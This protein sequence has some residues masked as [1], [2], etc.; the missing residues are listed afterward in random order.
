MRRWDDG[1]ISSEENGCNPTP[2]FFDSRLLQYQSSHD[3]AA[4]E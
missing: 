3:V 2:L 1:M 4:S